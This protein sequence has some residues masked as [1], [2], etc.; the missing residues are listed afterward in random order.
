M[1]DMRIQVNPFEMLSVLEYTGCQ[2]VNEHGTV[3]ISGIIESEKKETYLR[4][5]AQ[6]TWVQV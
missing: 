2:E 6:E 3:F 5:A 1:K 4:E